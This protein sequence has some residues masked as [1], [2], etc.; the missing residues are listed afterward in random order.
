MNLSLQEIKTIQAI[1]LVFGGDEFLLQ[2]FFHQKGSYPRYTPEKMILF[3]KDFSNDDFT[4]I[5]IA[6]SLMESTTVSLKE[7]LALEE[8]KFIN[9]L[10]GFLYF[11]EIPSQLDE[12]C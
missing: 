11:K 3:A 9:T 10:N 12:R 5:K 6:L 4:L 1:H 7:I 8:E 2:F